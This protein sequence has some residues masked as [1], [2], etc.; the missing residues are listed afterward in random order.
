MQGGEIKMGRRTKEALFSKCDGYCIACM[1][2][3]YCP[4]MGCYL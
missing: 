2:L 1:L 4:P 3:Y